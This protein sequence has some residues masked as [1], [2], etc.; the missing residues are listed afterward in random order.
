[1]KIVLKQNVINIIVMAVAIAV[2]PV[3]VVL[4]W[5]TDSTLGE[6]IMITVLFGAMEIVGV[7]ELLK[8]IYWRIVV[9]DDGFVYRNRWGKEFSYSFSDIY[10]IS[11]KNRYYHVCLADNSI[12]VEYRAVENCLYFLDAAARH[13]VEIEEKV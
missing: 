11:A 9:Y 5:V 4:V 1:M 2:A 10:S 7:L 12:T 3:F 13:G 8:S 6:R